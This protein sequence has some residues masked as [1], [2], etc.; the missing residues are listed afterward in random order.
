MPCAVVENNYTAFCDSVNDLQKTHWKASQIKTQSDELRFVI[1]NAITNGFDAI[2]IT[3][4]GPGLYG[5]TKNDKLVERWLNQLIDEGIIESFWR[6]KVSE[7][8]V[9]IKKR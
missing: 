5:L 4:N 6:T 2:G 1:S 8:G 9:I 7:E 3:S